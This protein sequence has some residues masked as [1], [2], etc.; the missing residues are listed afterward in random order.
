M[1][2]STHCTNDMFTG[3]D[4]AILEL[5]PALA[6]AIL[7]RLA[8]FEQLHTADQN[9]TELQFADCSPMFS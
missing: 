1:L 6:T 9:L 4:V 8:L 5:T 2:L 7:R 3:C